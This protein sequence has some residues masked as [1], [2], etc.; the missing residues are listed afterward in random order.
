ME[1]VHQIVTINIKIYPHADNN[2]QQISFT[3]IYLPTPLPL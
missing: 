3:Y 2:L 1:H